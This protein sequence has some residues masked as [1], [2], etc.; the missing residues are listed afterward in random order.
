MPIFL[1]KYPHLYGFY[2]NI[3]I[4]KISALGRSKKS[5]SS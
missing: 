3:G 5:T 1:R 4:K 2:E